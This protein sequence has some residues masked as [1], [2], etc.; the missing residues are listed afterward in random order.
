[1]SELKGNPNRNARFVCHLALVM[2]GTL[3]HVVGTLEGTIAESASGT[4]GFGYDPIFIPNG[5]SQSL[6]E[7]G[8]D[9]KNNISHRALAVAQLMEEIKKQEI[10]FAKP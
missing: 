8:V 6:S 10:V 9:Q 3:V 2:E 7:I 1:M 5:Y 4:D